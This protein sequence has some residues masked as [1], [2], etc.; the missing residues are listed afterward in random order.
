MMKKIYFFVLGFSCFYAYGQD[1]QPALTPPRVTIWIHGTDP[2]QFFP[3]I[4]CALFEKALTYFEKSIP[5][6][7]PLKDIPSDSYMRV[8]SQ[9]LAEVSPDLFPAEHFYQFGWSGDLSVAIRRSYGHQLYQEIKALVS[10]YT[11]QY[12]CAPILTLISHSHGGNVVLHMH[13]LYTEDE[14]PFEIERLVLLACPIQAETV[15]YTQSSLFRSII[16]AYS[17]DDIVQVMDPQ[18]IQPFLASGKKNFSKAWNTA[19]HRSVFSGRTIKNTPHIKNVSV[20]WCSGVPWKECYKYIPKNKTSPVKALS[21]C[22]DFFNSK[23][24]LSHVEI[25]MPFFLKHIPAI[26]ALS[27]AYSNSGIDKHTLDGTLSL[28]I[29]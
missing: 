25:K 6:I 2:K 17:K 3:S 1:I 7:I 11:E 24:G 27:D 20:A 5:G 22:A 10:R 14:N 28:C 4:A 19:T 12:G 21:D 18:W 9:V 8:I 16:N 15:G 29:S 26:F 23:R 13:E